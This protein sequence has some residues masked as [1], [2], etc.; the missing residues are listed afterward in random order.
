MTERNVFGLVVRVLGL[1]LAGYWGLLELYSGFGRLAEPSKGAAGPYFIVGL[2]CLI[3][4]ILLIKGNWLVSFAY[5]RE[6]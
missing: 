6:S 3:T 4:G 2:A 1:Y 5:G